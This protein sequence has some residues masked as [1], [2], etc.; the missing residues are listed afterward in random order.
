MFLIKLGGSLITDKQKPYTARLHVIRRLSQ[1]ISE[2]RRKNKG[3]VFIVGHGGGSFPHF[4]A[5]EYKTQEGVINKNSIRGIAEVQ[6]AASKL[7]RIVV[8]EFIKVGENAVSFSPSSFL[9]TSNGEIKKAFLSSLIG[10][11]EL[12]ILPVVYGDVVFDDRKGCS[13]VSTE[14]LL[15][16]LAIRLR[17]NFKSTTIV[18]CGNTDGVYDKQGKTISRITKA[19]F[20]EFRKSIGGST[21]VD[22]TGG[23]LHKVQE[24]LRVTEKGIPVLI[25]NGKR[26]NE[27]YRCVVERNFDRVTIVSK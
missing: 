26:R 20:E 27:I 14:K 7:N 16:F 25:I 22:V 3:M 6:N 21:G 10:N 1:E 17:R 15:N 5:K 18:Y 11:L 8:E 24:A 13:I 2:L 9:V 12:G 23:M 19:V 4:P